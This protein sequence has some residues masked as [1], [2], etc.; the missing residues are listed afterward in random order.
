[1]A[2]KLVCNLRGIRGTGKSD[3][4]GAYTAALWL[5]EN[6]PKTLACN[7]SSY[8]NV[9]LLCET[10]AKKVFPR[11]EYPE[12][13]GVEE[14]HYAYRVRDRLRKQVLVPLRKTLELP[15]VYMRMVDD[16]AK[17]GKLNNCLAICDV[18]GSM[19]GIPMEVSVALEFLAKNSHACFS[20]SNLSFQHPSAIS[21]ASPKK[22]SCKCN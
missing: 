8:D 6:H 17:K 12:Y 2:L 18:S 1:M 22:I 9:T 3:R 20:V 11:D 4:E 13:E 16:M 21:H 14:A 5:H 7:D 10:I 15:E 19:S